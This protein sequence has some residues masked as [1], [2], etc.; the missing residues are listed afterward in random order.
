[1]SAMKTLS[2]LGKILIGSSLVEV[3]IFRLDIHNRSWILT[4]MTK[5]E[6]SDLKSAVDRVVE[7]EKAAYKSQLILDEAKLTLNRM[8]YNLEN[9]K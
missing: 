1:M 8:F 5:E 2:S 7:C 9:K 3:I 4:N 6:I